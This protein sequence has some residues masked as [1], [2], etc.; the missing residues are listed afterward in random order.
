MKTFQ[1]KLQPTVGKQL[2]ND[3]TFHPDCGKSKCAPYADELISMNE[4][5]DHRFQDFRSQESSLH[6]FSLP[7]DVNVE[8]APEEFQMELIEL[9]GNDNLKWDMKD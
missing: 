9:Q 8:Q 5:F 3:N 2:R 6:M 7:F 1:S 4:E